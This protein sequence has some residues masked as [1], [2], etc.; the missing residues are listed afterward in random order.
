[1]HLGPEVF[2]GAAGGDASLACAL[3][4]AIPG[5]V[6]RDLSEQHR[7]VPLVQAIR[8]AFPLDCLNDAVDGALI[9]P[10]I[11]INRVLDLQTA[12]D[13]LHR[14]QHARHDRARSGARQRQ[15]EEREILALRRGLRAAEGV[16]E[17]P[18]RQKQHGVLRHRA[19]ERRRQAFVQSFEAIHL[20]GVLNAVQRAGV[21]RAGVALDVLGLQ[22]HLDSVE[23]VVE[24]LA[25]EAAARAREEVDHAV[26]HDDANS[27]RRRATALSLRSLSAAGGRRRRPTR[28]RCLPPPIRLT[29]LCLRE[30]RSSSRCADHIRR[31]HPRDRLSFDQP[32]QRP[33][34]GAASDSH[35]PQPSRSLR[36]YTARR[37]LVLC[38]ATGG[39]E[40]AGNGAGGRR[41]FAARASNVGISDPKCER[42][43]GSRSSRSIKSSGA[44]PTA[45]CNWPLF[46]QGEA[47]PLASLSCAPIS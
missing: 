9:R 39:L 43:N 11:T 30:P 5:E 26:R 4:N 19:E 10:K 33:R 41:G 8:D 16:L 7:T 21:L 2:L 15:P 36:P 6:P 34:T 20:H 24:E 28:T 44:L 1:M 31:S 37:A 12:L 23:R 27:H 47:V 14:R 38:N 46:R 32:H 17:D 13:E 22:E 25:R 35:T 42:R 45:R 40:P 18:V 3:I 29:G